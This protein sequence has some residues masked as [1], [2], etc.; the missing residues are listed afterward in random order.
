[1]H[2]ATRL[3]DEGTFVVNAEDLCFRLQ[4]LKLLG[5]VTCNS[6]D[7]AARVVRARRNRGGDERSRAV[8]SQS[9]RHGGHRFSGAFHHVVPARAMDVDIDESGNSG[10]PGGGNFRGSGRQ[11]HVLARANGFNH[12]VANQDARVRYFCRRS[13]GARSVQQNGGHRQINIVTEISCPTKRNGRE[14]SPARRE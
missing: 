3:V 13:Q 12:A 5:D 14:P 4:R 9:L 11:G 1:M 10:L 6:F 8:P 2:A 7:A